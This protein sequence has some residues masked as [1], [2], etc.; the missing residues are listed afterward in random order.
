MKKRFLAAGL[1][2]ATLGVSACGTHPG[3][4]VIVNGTQYS[5]ADVSEASQQ[6][7][8]ALQNNITPAMVVNYLSYKDAFEQV[9]K[10]HNVAVAVGDVCN[11]FTEQ[12]KH[13]GVKFTPTTVDLLHFFSNNQAVQQVAQDP[14]SGGADQLNAELAQA[15]EKQHLNVNPRYGQLA[16]GNVLT[17]STLPGVLAQNV[18]AQMSGDN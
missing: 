18:P 16:P 7:S 10:D 9:A 2:A 4:A 5:Q 17:A 12:E 8:Q 3:A 14:K 11:Q 13:L 15:Q 6:L 1:L